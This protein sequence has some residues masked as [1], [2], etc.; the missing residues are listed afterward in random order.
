M[1]RPHL[2]TCLAC[3]AKLREYRDAP[4]RVAALFPPVA[5]AAGGS[6]DGGPL[7]GLIEALVGATQDRAV[8]LGERVHTATE[9]A[10]GQKLAVVAASAAAVAGGGAAVEQVALPD[11][12]PARDQPAEVR[13]T[14]QPAT[15]EPEPEQPTQTA[16][17]AATATA[18]PATGRHP[19]PSARAARHAAAGPGERIHAG[20]GGG[21]PGEPDARAR[22]VGEQRPGARCAGGGSTGGGGSAGGGEFGP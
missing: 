6:G 4:A 1:L 18:G 21:T 9:L 11:G 16:P 13:T 2:K 19:F 22:D 10:T 20:A 17:I 8:A 3:R 15:A 14:E 7:R 12:V 5:L